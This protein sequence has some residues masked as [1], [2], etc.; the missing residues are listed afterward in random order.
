MFD[1]RTLAA[2]RATMNRCRRLA[3]ADRRP[4][5]DRRLPAVRRN[6]TALF[7]PESG[8]EIWRNTRIY[9]SLSAARGK[10]YPPQFGI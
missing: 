2:W 10:K 1:H 3:A 7:M 8:R 9:P 4:S 6:R 5:D